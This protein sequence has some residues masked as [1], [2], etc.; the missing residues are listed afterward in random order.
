MNRPVLQCE[1]CDKIFFYKSHLDR[2]RW[3][4]T[5]E[6]NY[7]CTHCDQKFRLKHH[8][9]KHIMRHHQSNSTWV[10]GVAGLVLLWSKVSTQTPHQ[11]THY[12]PSSVQLNLRLRGSWFSLIVIKSFNLNTTREKHYAPSSILLNLRLRVNAIIHVHIVIKQ[13]FWLKCR[14][15]MHIMRHHQFY[16]WIHCWTNMGMPRYPCR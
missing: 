1:F 13:K 3:T 16:S 9:R 12:A 10:W 5:G 2:H 6:R 7:P 14:A 11:K 8:V 4:H 15:R